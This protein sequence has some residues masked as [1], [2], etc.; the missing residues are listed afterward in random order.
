MVS[1]CPPT[2]WDRNRGCAPRQIVAPSPSSSRAHQRL[3]YAIGRASVPEQVRLLDQKPGVLEHPERMGY[4]VGL[5]ADV[6]RD[7]AARRVALGD[8]GEHGMIK[9]RVA[10][11]GLLHEQVPGLTEQRSLRV[12]HGPDHPGVEVAQV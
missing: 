6:T 1:K 12:Q 4:L 2:I 7:A 8:G 5:P 11:L 10:D 9:R 3:T